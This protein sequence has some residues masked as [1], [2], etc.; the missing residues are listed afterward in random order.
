MSVKISDDNRKG[1]KVHIGTSFSRFQ[2]SLRPWVHIC[3]E[4]PGY[5]CA[6]RCDKHTASSGWTYRVAQKSHETSV[7]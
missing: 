4:N 6:K 7:K 2:S 1:G 3:N 5:A